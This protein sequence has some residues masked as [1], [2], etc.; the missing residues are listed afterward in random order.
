MFGKSCKSFIGI[1]IKKPTIHLSFAQLEK[2]TIRGPERIRQSHLACLKTSLSSTYIIHL[3][4]DPH[5][6][7]R[8]SLIARKVVAERRGMSRSVIFRYRCRRLT[9]RQKGGSWVD[10]FGS[11]STCEHGVA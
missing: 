9:D 2:P 7:S 3:L 11:C 4:N 5:N 10:A 6:L 1:V 8:L